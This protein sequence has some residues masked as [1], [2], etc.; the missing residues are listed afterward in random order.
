MSDIVSYRKAS[1][2]YGRM[3]YAAA[4][5]IWKPLAEEGDMLSQSRMGT[6]NDFGKGMEKK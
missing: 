6:C 3:D 1:D 5:A 2:A 4:V